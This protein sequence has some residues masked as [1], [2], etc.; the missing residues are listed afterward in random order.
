MLTMKMKLVKTG[1]LL[2][3]MIAATAIVISNASAQAWPHAMVGEV[4]DTE[5]LCVPGALVTIQNERTGYTIETSTNSTGMYQTDISNLP[6]GYVIG[7]SLKVTATWEGL[8][9]SNTALVSSSP[10]D[11]CNVVVSPQTGR[12]IVVLIGI[13][14]CGAAII[15]IAIIY[16]RGGN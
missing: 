3:L 1:I 10:F 6:E 9:G 14:V 2:S 15:A 8:S 7:D 12:N 4:T 16:F 11:V 13:A 5:G